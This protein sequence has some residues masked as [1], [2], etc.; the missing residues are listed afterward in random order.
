[1]IKI[2]RDIMYI[3]IFIEMNACIYMS[4]CIYT[5]FLKKIDVKKYQTSRINTEQSIRAKE[6]E[7]HVKLPLVSTVQ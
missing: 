1:V 3:C 5:V 6:N 2:D 4:I 7:A